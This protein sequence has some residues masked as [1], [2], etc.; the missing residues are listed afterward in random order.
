MAPLIL[1]S[2]SNAPVACQGSACKAEHHV[3]IFMC[4]GDGRRQ[5]G[6]HSN[7]PS[8]KKK[9]ME[10]QRQ[11]FYDRRAR[12]AGSR[13]ISPEGGICLLAGPIFSQGRPHLGV[14]SEP[15]SEEEEEEE[16]RQGAQEGTHQRREPR[17]RFPLPAILRVIQRSV[18]VGRIRTG[19]GGNNSRCLGDR[20]MQSQARGNLWAGEWLGKLCRSNRLL[21]F[22]L[23]PS[24]RFASLKMRGPSDVAGADH[25]KRGSI[26]T[27]IINT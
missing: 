27:T 5:L 23:T 24:W 6:G 3:E 7:T 20:G 14:G 16:E 26:R 13:R 10:T 8:P 21:V 22:R 2:H 19:V 4:D 11:T 12:F 1:I 25:L 17:A 15:G 9:T 18:S